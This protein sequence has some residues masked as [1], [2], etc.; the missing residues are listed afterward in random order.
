MIDAHNFRIYKEACRIVF[1]A[2]FFVISS[3][4]FSQTDYDSLNTET[5]HSN[6]TRRLLDIITVSP[7]TNYEAIDNIS[8]ENYL[9]YSGMK[10]RRIEIQQLNVFGSDI[11]DPTISSANQL[12][13]IL[14]KTHVNTAERIIRNNLLFKTG[15]TIS[16]LTLSDNER[17]LRELS[18]INDARIFVVPISEDEADIVVVTKDVYSI[19]FD[20][21]LA[22]LK[23]GHFAVFDRNLIG[24]GH[25]IE[26]D[27]PFDFTKTSNRLGFG[28]NYSVSNIKHSFIDFK[29]FYVKGFGIETYGLKLIRPLVAY[30]TKYAGGISINR[31]HTTEDLDTMAIASPLSYTLQDYWLLRSFL[32]NSSKVQ[33]IIIGARYYNNNIFERPFI[34]EDS[35]HSLQQYKIFLGSIAYSRQKYYKTNLIYAYGR[36]EDIPFGALVRITAGKELNEFKNRFYLGFDASTGRSV[37]KLGYFYASMA[38]GG[39]WYENEPEQGILSANI[40]YFSNHI[41]AGKYKVRNFVN[42]NYTRGVNRFSDEY[43]NFINKNGFAGFKNDTIMGSQRFSVGVESALFCPSDIWGF[44]FVVYGFADMGLLRGT[45]LFASQNFNLTSIGLGVR[46]R[47]DNLVFSTLQIRLAYY[48]SRPDFSKL[49]N[50][51]L[52]G[53][54]LFR[55]PNFVPEPPA[56]IQYR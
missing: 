9:I 12:T 33:R 17:I 51:V 6:L 30:T 36:T 15:D 41:T 49:D 20:V 19:G 37:R 28:F 32:I 53:E 2:S 29:T 48:P 7:A 10:I 44:K 55:H 11:N 27:M 43:L 21:N 16:P 50:I 22:G 39:Y 4:L 26:F 42:L 47:N 45:N 25:S 23:R 46:I 3:D 5:S 40:N 56:I 14:N 35:Y 34:F 52:S 24:L 18:Y 31:M 8:D 13:N 38:V 54:Q 1:L